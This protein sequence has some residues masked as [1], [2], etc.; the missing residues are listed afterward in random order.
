MAL[1][2]DGAEVI[3]AE[4]ARRELYLLVVEKPLNMAAS[5]DNTGGGGSEREQRGRVS[6]GWAHT[7]PACPMSLL[8]MSSVPCIHL[9][10]PSKRGAAPQCPVSC[11]A[12]RCGPHSLGSLDAERSVLM[13]TACLLPSPAER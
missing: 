7:T 13:L 4:R 12:L 8:G 5:Q 10:Q 1:W 3:G 6:I 9:H 2:L 11:L